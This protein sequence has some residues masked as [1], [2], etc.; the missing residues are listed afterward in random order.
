MQRR[1]HSGHQIILASG[2]RNPE[3]NRKVFILGVEDGA[4][5]II[6]YLFN[7]PQ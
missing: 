3:P 4:W 1:T 6:R 7:T 2:A 5:K